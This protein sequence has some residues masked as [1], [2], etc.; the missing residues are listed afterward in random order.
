MGKHL[1]DII[2][3]GRSSF[4]GRPLLGR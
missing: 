4:T 3:S 2:C 1:T